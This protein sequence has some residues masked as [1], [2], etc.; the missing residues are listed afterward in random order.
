MESQ[1][2]AILSYAIHKLDKTPISH[3]AQIYV[4]EIG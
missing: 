1:T 4:T 2:P 3:L